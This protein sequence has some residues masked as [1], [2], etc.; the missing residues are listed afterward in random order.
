MFQSDPERVGE[1]VQMDLRA[2][3]AIDHSVVRHGGTSTERR[4]I[5]G[6]QPGAARSRPV[7]LRSGTA[8]CRRR[9]RRRLSVRRQPGRERKNRFPSGSLILTRT[10][11]GR[12]PTSWMADVGG[13]LPPL[14][15]RRVD[16]PTRQRTGMLVHRGGAGR[17]RISARPGTGRDWRTRYPRA[18][19]AFAA[20]EALVQPWRRLCRRLL[21]P[22]WS[23]PASLSM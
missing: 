10:C 9:A 2:E 17:S 20:C 5:V 18:P 19:P 16:Q 4:P 6:T 15:V 13:L 8:E 12:G 14:S 23:F 11:G 7:L 1:R 3:H 21:P 22:V